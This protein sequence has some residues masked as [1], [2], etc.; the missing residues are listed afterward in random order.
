[1]QTSR[2]KQAVKIAAVIEPGNLNGPIVGTVRAVRRDGLWSD[3]ASTPGRPDPFLSVVVPRPPEVYGPEWVE[4][5]SAKR[6]AYAANLQQT[7]RGMQDGMRH[8]CDDVD[9]CGVMELRADPPTADPNIRTI[10]FGSLGT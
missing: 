6:D 9:V 7:R 8:R 5:R 10:L 3:E 2:A 1:M 4:R